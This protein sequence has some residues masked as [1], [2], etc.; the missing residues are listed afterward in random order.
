MSDYEILARRVIHEWGDGDARSEV[1]AVHETESDT[2]EVRTCYYQDNGRFGQSAPTFPAD[3]DIAETL[4]DAIL[5]MTEEARRARQRA[6]F[7]ELED[8][9]DDLGYERAK[10]L[11]ER[12]AE[13]DDETEE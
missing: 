12:E 3:A 6:R 4:A 8:L 5:D 7:D 2:Y 10:T 1:Q 11:L 13:A 9:I